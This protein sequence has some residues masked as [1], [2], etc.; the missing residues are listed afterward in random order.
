MN[1]TNEVNDVRLFKY[2]CK[3]HKVL[4]HPR[5]GDGKKHNEKQPQKILSFQ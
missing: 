4:F 3:F 5:Y 1:S 2:A